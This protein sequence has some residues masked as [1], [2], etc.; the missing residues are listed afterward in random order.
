LWVADDGESF[1]MV[2][3]ACDTYEVRPLDDGRTEVRIVI[4]PQFVDLW[5]A[6]LSD[7]RATPAEAGLPTDG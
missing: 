3:E 1:S 7:L 6:K 2:Q 5:L 4:A